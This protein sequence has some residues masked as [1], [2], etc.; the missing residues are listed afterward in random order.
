MKPG[1]FDLISPAPILLPGAG[2][3]LSPTL[4]DIS[5]LGLRT[6][7]YYL[8]VLSMDVKTYVSMAQ[9]PAQHDFLSEEDL[10]HLNLFDLLTASASSAAHLAAI[11]NFFLKENV[12]FS[13]GEGCFV[14]TAE[15]DLQSGPVAG[16]ITRENYEALCSLICRRNNIRFQRELPLSGVKS[17][18]AR[19]I[20]KKLKKGRD[21]KAKSGKK[22]DASTELGNIISAVAS[23]H[24]SL[25][26][27][28]IW[29]ITVFQLWDAFSRLSNNQIY[30]IESMSVAAWGNKDNR[31]DAA[32]WFKPLDFGKEDFF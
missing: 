6:Y 31:F 30:N 18:K 29:D 4:R 12:S 24:P 8:S 11:L 26:P 2:S 10:F 1:Y 19:E 7:Y 32:G 5:V 28:N 25:N 3:V 22:A 16:K 17:K 21:E 27:V 13:K 14:V 23:R 9:T 15:G 20:M